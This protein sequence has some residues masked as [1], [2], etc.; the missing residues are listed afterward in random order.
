MSQGASYKGATPRQSEQLPS[1]ANRL[2]ADVLLLLP[3]K[4]PFSGWLFLGLT[5]LTLFSSLFVVFAAYENRLAYAELRKLEQQQIQYE[6]EWGQLLLERSTLASPNRI[7]KIARESL[8]MQVVSPKQ[9]K[10]VQ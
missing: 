8:Q 9:V 1:R 10:V 6:V 4:L 7:E 2:K 5:L 3:K